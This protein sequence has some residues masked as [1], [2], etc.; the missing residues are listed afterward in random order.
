MV[1]VELVLTK[2]DLSIKKD[3]IVFSVLAVRFDFGVT[4]KGDSRLTDLV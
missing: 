3:L 4:C 1:A 2:L